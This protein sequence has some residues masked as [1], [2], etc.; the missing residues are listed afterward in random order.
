M[1]DRRPLARWREPPQAAHGD[2]RRQ[3][4]DDRPHA[5]AR[6]SVEV[7]QPLQ[8]RRCGE[9]QRVDRVAGEGSEEH[10]VVQG[11]SAERSQRGGLPA[12]SLLLA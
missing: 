7:P 9:G 5:V 1:H 10:P 12:P 3:R 4:R 6:L 8:Q 2:Q 11:M